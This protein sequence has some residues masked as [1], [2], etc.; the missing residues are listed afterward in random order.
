MNIRSC[1]HGVGV[2]ERASRP[3]VLAVVL[4]AILT[5]SHVGSTHA[6]E[7]VEAR[8]I[9]RPNQAIP[10]ELPGLDD[11]SIRELWREGIELEEAGDLIGSNDRYQ[12]IADRLGTSAYPYWRMAR[13]YWHQHLNVPKTDKDQ[14]IFYL[15]LSDQMADRGLALDDQCTECMLWKYAALGRL[16][17]I[18]GLLSA[19]G[20]A[21][22]LAN[23]LEQGIELSAK[24]G[25]DSSNTTLAEF[26]Y[27]SATFY[28]MVPDWF[29]LR[30]VVGVQGNKERAIDDARKAVSLAETHLEYQVELGATLLCFGEAKTKPERTEEGLELLRRVEAYPLTPE[31]D[32]MDQV[33]AQMLLES[34]GKACKFSRIGFIDVDSVAAKGMD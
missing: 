34:P 6:S 24:K 5:L 27:A 14:R 1:R 19:A 10:S 29:W 32:A 16:P 9:D 12:I 25:E 28:R 23:L 8:N 31:S 3:A 22:T 2:V 26:Y 11:P 4:S 13:N 7:V 20:D 15:E 18:K 21:K 17:T 30:W 33:F